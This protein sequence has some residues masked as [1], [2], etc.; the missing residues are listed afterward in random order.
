MWLLALGIYALGTAGMEKRPFTGNKPN[1]MAMLPRQS[2]NHFHPNTTEKSKP[3]KPKGATL[4]TSD[5]GKW[6]QQ[7]VNTSQHSPNLQPNA[8]L[9]LIYLTFTLTESPQWL[10]TH[11]TSH[12]RALRA[13]SVGHWPHLEIFLEAPLLKA[14]IFTP[15]HNTAS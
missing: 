6:L 1:S 11:K 9:N 8:E 15:K 3:A 5:R 13:G 4:L 2:S 14:S 7:A 12:S 10:P